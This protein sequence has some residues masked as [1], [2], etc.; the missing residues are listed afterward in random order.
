MDPHLCSWRKD[1]DKGGSEYE[2]CPSKATPSTLSFN[3]GRIDMTWPWAVVIVF[4]APVILIAG[5]LAVE[6]YKEFKEKRDGS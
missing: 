1:V 5:G 6:Y 2:D 3:H 4:T